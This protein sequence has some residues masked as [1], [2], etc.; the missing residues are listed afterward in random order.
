MKRIIPIGVFL[1]SVMSLAAADHE[2]IYAEGYPLRRDSVGLENDIAI[3][4]SLEAGDSIITAQSDFVELEAGGYSVKIDENTVF[5]LR[6]LENQGQKSDV[7]TCVLGKLSF[8]RDKILGTEPWLATNSAICG[9][10]G[11]DVTLYAGVDGSTIVVVNDGAAEVEAAGKTV[12]LA[13][14]SGVEVET[15]SAPGEPFAAL[16]REIDFS[17]W[18]ERRL[19]GMLKDPV[20]AAEKV[21]SQLRYYIEQIGLIHPQYLDLRRQIESMRDKVQAVIKEKGQEAGKEFGKENLTPLQLKATYQY[22]NIRYYA[23]SALSLRRFVS[24]RMYA[25]LK[26]RYI[27]KPDNK[28]YKKF[29]E[30][31]NNVLELFEREVAESFIVEADI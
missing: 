4:D 30:A 17:E 5:S 26:A 29:L 22:L 13:K 7:L 31:H 9:V 12:E 27:T 11:T 1:I 28:T 2:V 21:K 10:R 18:N 15:G 14:G 20:A 8:S 6:E 3:G 16:E 23:L 19:A 25:I 24:G